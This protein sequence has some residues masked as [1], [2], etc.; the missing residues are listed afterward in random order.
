MV[1][2]RH[3][4]IAPAKDGK[5][6]L[7]D[8]QSRNGTHLNGRKLAV[9]IALNAGDKIDFG[10]Q[11]KAVFQF[12]SA[13]G[14]PLT[15]MLSQVFGEMA[16][17]VEW[18]VGDNI[19]GIYEVTGILGQGGMGRV[20]KA[21][22]KS[23]NMD[24]AV[25]SPLP[26]LFSDEKAIESFVREAETWVNLNLHP[27]VVQCFYVRTIG[28]IP[29]IFGEYVPGGTLHHRIAQK[30]LT[31]LDQILDVAIQFAWGLHSAHEQGLV[32]QDVKPA[33]VL[34]TTDGCPKVTDF[35]LA[36]SRPASTNSEPA[37]EN[38]L[39]SLAGG[40]PAYISPEQARGKKLSRK[41]DIWSWGL[42]VLQMF[43]G[44]V[45]WEY[46]LQAPKVLK[47]YQGFL[48]QRFLIPMPKKVAKLLGLCF[49]IKP[50]ARPE[51]LAEVAAECQEIYREACK[52]EY[53]RRQPRATE[54]VADGL[55]NRAVSLLD[56][57]NQELAIE[58]LEKAILVDPNHC[59]SIFN[60]KLHEW[61]TA[62]ITDEEVLRAV[63]DID[64]SAPEKWLRYYLL[65]SVHLER[66]DSNSCLDSLLRATNLGADKESE[67]F[68]RLVAAAREGMASSRG[69]ARVFQDED[70]LVNAVSLTPDGRFALTCGKRLRLWDTATG[71]CL[72]VVDNRCGPVSAIA[73]S[74]SGRYAVTVC[75]SAAIDVWNLETGERI[76]RLEGHDG[77]VRCLCFSTDDRLAVSGGDDGRI[78]LWDVVT[79]K[80]VRRYE[81]LGSKVA[82][83]CVDDQNRYVTGSTYRD[84]AAP[85]CHTA[86]VWDFAT[87]RR[88]CEFP[89]EW[90]TSGVARLGQRRTVLTTNGQQLSLWDVPQGV[91]LHTYSVEPSTPHRV[92]LSSDSSLALSASPFEEYLRVWDL[93]N[94]R[95]VFS[96]RGDGVQDLDCIAATPDMR[97]AISRSLAS[98]FITHLRLA[99]SPSAFRAPPRFSRGVS[100]ATA[101]GAE[102]IYQQHLLLART[103][104]QKR[105]FIAA[106]RSLR[107]ARSQKGCSRR[108][109]A[110]GV[111]TELYTKLPRIEFR[112]GWETAAIGDARTNQACFSDDRRLILTAY[113][114]ALR[115]WDVQSNTCVREFFGAHHNIDL[116]I[117][118]KLALSTDGAD[119]YH[120]GP[121]MDSIRLWDLT[122]GECVR[123]IEP[124]GGEYI[125]SIRFTRDSRFILAAS[126]Q[127]SGDKAL[128]LW[129]AHSGRLLRSK[130]V[131]GS[132]LDVCITPDDQYVILA[133][134]GGRLSI[135]DLKTFQCV[136]QWSASAG[137][138]HCAICLSR[139]G[140]YIL[141]AGRDRDGTNTLK[142]WEM[143]TSTLVQS[144]G[145]EKYPISCICLSIDTKFALA[146]NHEGEVS[147]SCL[148]SGKCLHRFHCH[149]G[150]ITALEISMDGSVFV[151]GSSSSP[152]K[153]WTLDWELEAREPADWDEGCRPYLVNFL[154][155]HTPSVGELPVDRRPTEP[156]ITLA[157]TRQGK[158]SWTDDDFKGLH[159]TL[160]CA[161]YGWLRPEGV[162][163]ELEKMAATWKEPPTLLPLKEGEH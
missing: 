71:S 36:R 117:D 48:G 93:T 42:C 56:L 8:L 100:S 80:Y 92:W 111:W 149:T 2:R 116:S 95:N 49:Q 153:K 57:G 119:R 34:M 46:G 24:L 140:Q 74:A 163:R 138:G 91:R 136:R 51:H 75:E 139:C 13:E 76:Q 126:F 86:G 68:L 134:S 54:H 161:G 151:S 90:S 52:R 27:N 109:E 108:P 10:G 44:G 62:K 28:G 154:A 159:Y 64:S 123:R 103:C 152:L 141:T 94:G 135:W 35:G 65:A 112:D 22:H 25:K 88:L 87:G 143:S 131:E 1:S 113:D 9:P 58:L 125:Q 104:V 105:D 37:N 150:G 70:G 18:K 19:L 66:G 83:V 107:T 5:L 133:E 55:N 132:G 120:K 67:E 43:I 53:C 23:W 130:R 20:Y 41:T 21:H 26:N 81:E 7:T 47:A 127:L 82:S 121:K 50:D 101:S 158:P 145:G 6:Y 73:V 146:G 137:D 60:L 11:G 77:N 14:E 148:N 29:R 99:N 45:T 59:E 124:N 115:L 110:I 129:D 69:V 144:L 118:G 32:H 96:F 3:A 79:G 84:T 160:G 33:N 98:A 162:R 106:A 156:E 89:D 12:D 72:R 39:V 61:R 31:Q 15:Q 147:L 16:A 17:P 85:W 30:K 155:F 97:H 122:T 40:T 142:L 38:T 78:L 102:D 114:D 157:L 128:N 4:Q 63:R